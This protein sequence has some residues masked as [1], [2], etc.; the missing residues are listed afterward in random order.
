MSETKEKE[1]KTGVKY[2]YWLKMIQDATKNQL[3]YYNNIISENQKFFQ[4]RKNLETVLN[5]VR[6]KLYDENIK[7]EELEHVRDVLREVIADQKP[8]FN[9][10]KKC[11]VKLGDTIR[12]LNDEFNVRH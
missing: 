12:V 9:A 10:I 2:D 11:I 3:I 8:N 6:D 1:N 5:K 7:S 4:E